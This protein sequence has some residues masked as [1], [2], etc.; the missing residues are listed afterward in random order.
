M[1]GK[2]YICTGF[3]NSFSGPFA[4]FQPNKEK[5]FHYNTKHYLTFNI[6]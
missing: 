6:I 5:H 1:V 4:A 3:G 2:P